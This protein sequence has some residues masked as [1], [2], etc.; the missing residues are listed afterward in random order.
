MSFLI[1]VLGFL[2]TCW[3]VC[4]AVQLTGLVICLHGAAKITH[5]AQRLVS[6]VSQWHA[7]ATCT[8]NAVTASAAKTSG[9]DASEQDPAVLYGPAH[10]LLYNGSSDDLESL[11][12]SFPC[13][14]ESSMHDMEAYQK[15]HA[16]GRFIILLENYFLYSF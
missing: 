1:G 4:T 6:I 3:Q 12:P 14:L 8:P 5:Q 9:I 15:R 16:L 7:L 11:M 10:P 13:G 2:G